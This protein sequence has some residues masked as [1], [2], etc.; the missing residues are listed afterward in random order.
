MEPV[1]TALIIAGAVIAAAA[2]T[3][4]IVR[5]K[6]KSAARKYLGTDLK[7]AAEMIGRGSQDEANLP[8]PISNVSEM[9]RPKLERDFPAI[10]YERFTALAEAVLLSVLRAISCG[11]AD[12]LTDVT[13]AMREKVVSIIANNARKGVTEHYDDVTLHRTAI[14]DYR[15]GEDKAVAVFEISF[16]CEHFTEGGRKSKAPVHCE[17]AASV[18]LCYGR[19]FAEKSMTL[20]RSHNCPNCGAPV[21]AVGGKMLQCRYCGTGITEDIHGSWL[22]DSFNLIK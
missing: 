11:N 4:L 19:E 1:F 9:Y 5:A 10:T 13:D 21:Y 15:S 22:A 8:K 20:T 2:V 7:G 6:L 18:T 3:V 16:G 17:L 12:G 14:A